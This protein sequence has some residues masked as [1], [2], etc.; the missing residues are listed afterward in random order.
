[1]IRNLNMDYWKPNT[2]GPHAREPSAENPVLLQTRPAT[3]D[4]AGTVP[5]ISVKAF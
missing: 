4:N 2:A 5:T 1:M 3:S